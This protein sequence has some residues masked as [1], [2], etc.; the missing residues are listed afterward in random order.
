MDAATAPRGEALKSRG[1]SRHSIVHVA[2]LHERKIL[3][4][5]NLTDDDRSAK[6]RGTMDAEK[7]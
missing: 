1:F 2:E 3:A 4:R 7:E 6:G 5:K